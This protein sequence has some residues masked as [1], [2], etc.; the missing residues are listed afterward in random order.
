M[1]RELKTPLII[2]VRRSK[3][4]FGIKDT[5]RR[6][7]MCAEFLQLHRFKMAVC[8]KNEKEALTAMRKSATRLDKLRKR[9]E[10]R[11]YYYPTIRP[12]LESKIHFIVCLPRGFIKQDKMTT[13]EKQ[14]DNWT[15]N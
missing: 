4:E 13:L 15:L 10:V 7:T 11:G 14:L 3:A 6:H 8:L 12:R 9:V 1:I 5:W 2:P